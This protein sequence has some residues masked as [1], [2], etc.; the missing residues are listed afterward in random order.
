MLSSGRKTVRGIVNSDISEVICNV[1]FQY[2]VQ[3]SPS[4][5]ISDHELLYTL[6]NLFNETHA[7]VAKSA[8]LPFG[9]NICVAKSR[10]C[11]ADQHIIDSN[12]SFGSP[13]GVGLQ[14]G[15]IAKDFQGMFLRCHSSVRGFDLYPH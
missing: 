13:G 2:R 6:A 1:R 7:L 9:V 4:H 11:G 5:A 14:A 12:C 15:I 8:A 10:V 3:P